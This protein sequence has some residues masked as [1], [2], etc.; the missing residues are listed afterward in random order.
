M[1]LAVLLGQIL[2]NGC[3]GELGAEGVSI[4]EDKV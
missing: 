1:E 4:S 3:G 2:Q